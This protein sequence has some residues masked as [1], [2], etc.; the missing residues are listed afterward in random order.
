VNSFF[1]CPIRELTFLWPALAYAF[2]GWRRP[3][4][5]LAYLA[6]AF[7]NRLTKQSKPMSAIITRFC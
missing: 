6:Q 5:K 7:E 1:F 3:R 4:A 2:A